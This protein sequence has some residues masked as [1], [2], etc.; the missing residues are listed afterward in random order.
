MSN[1]RI[2]ELDFDSIKSNLKDFLKN[3]TDDD[4]APY[5]TDFDYE[6][7]GLSILLD[8]LSY[9]T[10]YNAYLASMVINEMFLDSAVKRASAVSIAKHLGYTPLSVQGARAKITFDVTSPTNNPT[11]LTLERF[12]PFTTTIDENALTFVNLNAVTIQ[13]NVGTYTFTDIEVVEGIP[14]EY[15]YTVDLSGPAEKYVIP[16]ENVDTTT[17]QVVVQNSLVDTTS[18]L[19][20]LSDDTLNLDG[21][22]KVFFL[23]ENSTGRFQIHFGDNILGKKLTRGNLVKITYLVSNGKLGNVSGNIDQEFFCSTRIG[24]GNVGVAIIPSINSRGGLER[25]TIESIRFKAPKFSASQNR[26]VTANDYKSLIQKNYPLVE[27]VSVY[28]GD[29]ESPPKY[30][31][32]IISL[33]PYDGF[34][35]TQEIKNDIASLVLQNKQVLSIL[36]EFIE[37]EYFYINLSIN[38]KYNPK[39]STLSGTEIKNSVITAINSYFSAD[40]QQF[41]KDFVYSRLSRN[42]D[43]VDNSIVGN[44][45]TVKLH[46][47]L[48]PVFNFDNVYDVGNTIKFK[49]GLEPGSLEST[50]FVV[51][52]KGNSVEARIKDIPKDA[53]PNRTGTGILVLF[54]ADTEVLLDSN[55]GSIN[56]GTGVIIITNLRLT[57]YTHDTSDV[58]LTAIVQDSYL[59]VTVSKNE[60]ILLDD[61][62][63]NGDTNRLQGITVNTITVTE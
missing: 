28:G 24:G 25:E 2:A 11:F 59:D 29:Q 10:H 12:T 37:P 63:F 62:T 18:A 22:S 34:E 27:S 23:E 17:I 45:M 52:Y 36:P 33:K 58:R 5:F 61:S 19:Y 7:S 44:L 38:V 3:Y 8:V 30:G 57:G 32:V 26:A 43:A 60:I 15:T 55:Y 50:R 6:G 47:R 39:I 14:L 49:N 31:K 13:P 40:L 51:T 9:N 41:D 4:G 35:I 48:N 1:L 16:N 53:I 42:I 21:T 54:N 20:E 46:K 56:Y